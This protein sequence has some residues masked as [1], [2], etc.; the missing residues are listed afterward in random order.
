MQITVIS[1]LG[2]ILLLAGSLGLSFLLIYV[3]DFSPATSYLS[4]A[5]GG[6][7][8]MGITAHEI[9][10]DLSIVTG[11]QVFRIFFIYFIIPPLLRYLFRIFNW[12]KASA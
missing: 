12:K 10:A 3:H 2:G 7:D 5:P 4:V 1:L 11:Y 8:Q 6:M 9:R